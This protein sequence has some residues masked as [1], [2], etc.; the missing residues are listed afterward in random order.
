MTRSELKELGETAARSLFPLLNGK[1]GFVLVLHGDTF[2][3]VDIHTNQPNTAPAV[4][5]L[6]SAADILS[7]LPDGKVPETIE[8]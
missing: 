4:H 8:N 5:M 1:A 3:A 7:K 2:C 6:E